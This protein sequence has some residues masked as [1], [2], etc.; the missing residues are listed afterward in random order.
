MITPIS[1]RKYKYRNLEEAWKLD[2]N[3][4]KQMKKVGEAGMK[5]YLLKHQA[6]PK[7]S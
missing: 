4:K 7:K 6:S 5:S 1:C 2:G 3:L